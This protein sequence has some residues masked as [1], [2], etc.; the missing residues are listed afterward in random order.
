MT[1]WPGRLAAALAVA[2]SAGLALAAPS[3]DLPEPGSYE[4]PAISHV[5][6]RSLLS[7]DGAE[8]PLLGLSPEQVAVVALVY[9]HCPDACPLTLSVLQ[10][11]DR[12]LEQEPA[13]AKRVRIVTVSFDPKRDTPERMAAL[14]EQLRP[15][16]DWRFLTA[17]SESDLRP[18][19]VDFGQDLLPLTNQDGDPNGILRHVLKVFLVDGAGDIR[20]I[21]SAELL[22]PE[23]LLIDVQTL[24]GEV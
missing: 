12:R 22:S 23:L 20:N 1:T 2:T 18:L 10:G 7:H 11:F 9:T 3:S 21:Y 24:L 8:A 16:A 6:E 5:E 17:A 15:R 13:L 19:L 14:R 4:L